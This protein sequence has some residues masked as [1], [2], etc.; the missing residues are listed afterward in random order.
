MHESAIVKYFLMAFSQLSSV[1]LEA[2]VAVAWRLPGNHSED[3][4]HLCYPMFAIIEYNLI[5]FV[6]AVQ[7]LI[8][9][10]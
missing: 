5:V 7:E 9:M 3:L 2:L 1:R 10:R 4:L 6:I 8:D